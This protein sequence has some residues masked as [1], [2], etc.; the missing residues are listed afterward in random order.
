MTGT[1]L[2]AF[3]ALVG[4]YLVLVCGIGLWN[5]RR[6]STEEG[7]LAAGRSLVL[8]AEGTSHD[9][10]RIKPFKSS[11]LSAAEFAPDGRPLAVQPVTIAYTRLDATPIG[12]HLRP[13][14]AWYGDMELVP[15]LWEAFETGPIDVVVELHKPL[16]I[17]EAGGRKELAQT[18]EWTVRAGVVRALSGAQ[19]TAPPPH[20]DEDLMEALGQAETGE[21]A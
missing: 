1:P 17:D 6:A 20:H 9:G 12:R 19:I 5:Y 7:F 18:V 8:F 14:F 13:F 2:M 21:A 3:Y 16:T 10:S 11:L 4:A 15:H